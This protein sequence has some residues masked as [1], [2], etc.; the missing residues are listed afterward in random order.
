LC[1]LNLPSIDVVY[2]VFFYKISKKSSKSEEFILNLGQTKIPTK[3]NLF[4]SI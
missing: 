3:I 2:V 1:F 4:F